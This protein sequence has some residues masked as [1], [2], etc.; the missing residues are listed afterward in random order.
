M[1]I[2][3]V[4]AVNTNAGSKRKLS[5][6]AKAIGIAMGLTLGSTAA[7]AFFKK[8]EMHHMVKEYGGE[9]N[10]ALTLGAFTVGLSS[11]FIISDFL[12]KKFSKQP[13]KNAIPKAV[14]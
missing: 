3:P 2:R 10:F 13:R 1:N 14:N 5:V 7:T 11:L 4:G 12:T 9:K 6:P 8:D